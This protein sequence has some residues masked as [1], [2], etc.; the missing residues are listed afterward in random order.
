[1]LLLYWPEPKALVCADEANLSSG[2]AS[3]ALLDR[4]SKSVPGVFRT[5]D[6]WSKV[7]KCKKKDES[8]GEAVTAMWARSVQKWRQLF[9]ASPSTSF[10]GKLRDLEDEEKMLSLRNMF[11]SKS[12][13]RK[14]APQSVVQASDMLYCSEN[15][16]TPE[17]V[18]IDALCGQG[19]SYFWHLELPWK[20]SKIHWK[21]NKPPASFHSWTAVC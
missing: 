2:Q 19:Q 1:M 20:G 15:Q 7:I 8:F 3:N 11:G 4:A 6:I 12:P 16:A 18:T 10:S 9:E 17:K 21:S 5:S 14:L 13:H